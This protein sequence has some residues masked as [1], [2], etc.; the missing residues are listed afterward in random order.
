MRIEVIK[1]PTDY[2]IKVVLMGMGL[3]YD[4]N[5]DILE[6]ERKQAHFE[7][8]ARELVKK[9]GSH[10]K[11]LRMLH[12]QFDLTAPLYLWKHLDQYKVG[13]TTLSTSTVHSIKKYRPL[14]KEHFEI[15]DDRILDLLNNIEDDLTLSKILPLSFLQRRLFDLNAQQILNIIHQRKGHKFKE[16]EILVDYMYSILPSFARQ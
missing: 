15:I 4:P 14:K 7:K 13:S 16:W 1:F 9:G 8:V 6:V 2:E 10:S 11:F 3:S 12:Y 5:L